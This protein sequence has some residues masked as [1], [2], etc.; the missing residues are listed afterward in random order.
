[1]I[2]ESEA[3]SKKN[4]KKSIHEKSSE[5]LKKQKFLPFELDN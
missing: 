4:R 2:R 1:M 5:S 3:A